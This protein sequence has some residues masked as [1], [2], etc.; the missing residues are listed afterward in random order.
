MG[1]MGLEFYRYEIM[2]KIFVLMALMMSL[3]SGC[4]IM[5]DKQE[6]S[7]VTAP[8]IMFDKIIKALDNKDHKT[9][10]NLFSTRVLEKTPNIDKEIDDLF[11]LYQGKF[12]SNSSFD[13]GAGTGEK[14]YGKWIYLNIGPHIKE[15]KTD[16]AIYEMTFNSV[17]V[18]DEYPDDIGLSRIL[19]KL[20]DGDKVIQTCMVGEE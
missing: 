12:V 7:N 9:L 2:R 6:I 18:H 13:S 8:K 14:R 20:K 4:S 3:L 15:L 19:L 1:Y 17:P 16:K 5:T 10:K 11:E